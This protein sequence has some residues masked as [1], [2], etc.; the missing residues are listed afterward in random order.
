[1]LYQIIYTSRAV[2]DITH[3]DLY[4]ILQTSIDENKK[5]NIT[6][7]LIYKNGH[8]RQLIEGSEPDIKQLY[9]NIVNDQR[10]E[11]T[12]TNVSRSVSNREFPLWAMGFCGSEDDDFSTFE[13]RDVVFKPDIFDEVGSRSD[14]LE[15]LRDFIVHD[16]Q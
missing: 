16:M 8:F 9:Q 12:E 13:K 14:S 5:H 11:V 3:L 15:L 6:G 1:M 2:K 4:N 10:H 7:F